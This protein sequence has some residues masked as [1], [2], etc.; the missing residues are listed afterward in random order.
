MDWKGRAALL[1]LLVGIVLANN[2]VR[3]S[4][5]AITDKL[6]DLRDLALV[7]GAP[8]TEMIAHGTKVRVEFA[9]EQPSAGKYTNKMTYHLQNPDGSWKEVVVDY[10]CREFN[11]KR[12]CYGKTCPIAD[13]KP[14]EVPK[15]IKD[16]MEVAKQATDVLKYMLINNPELIG[17]HKALRDCMEEKTKEEKAVESICFNKAI[18]DIEKAVAELQEEGYTLQKNP[19]GSQSW[20]KVTKATK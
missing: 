20:T 18:A 13:Y 8:A 1:L 3:Y 19:D 9:V 2:Q 4:N 10:E 12:L 7:G 15:N 6:Y 11:M 17:N 16:C 5:K 14:A